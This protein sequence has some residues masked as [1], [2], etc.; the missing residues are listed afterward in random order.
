MRRD[1]QLFFGEPN[2]I[3]PC[4]MQNA[5]TLAGI[6]AFFI[7]VPVLLS[8]CAALVLARYSL[9]DEVHLL[10]KVQ[11]AR[12]FAGNDHAHHTAGSHHQTAPQMA[13]DNSFDP[14]QN[15]RIQD[16][17]KHG[18]A[19]VE[20]LLS[21]EERHLLISS[22]SIKGVQHRVVRSIALWALVTFVAIW[23][24]SISSSQALFLIAVCGATG[25]SS[26]VAWKLLKYKTIA[27]EY[28]QLKSFI[29]EAQWEGQKITHEAAQL[30]MRSQI[31]VMLW[32]DR[33]RLAIQHR[34]RLVHEERPHLVEKRGPVGQA[35]QVRSLRRQSV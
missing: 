16:D 35:G 20:N 34:I 8:S 23:A 2:R 30:S 5:A 14:V 33:A 15:E 6:R 17:P 22:D 21:A 4:T 26:T 27:R 10:V 7:W 24:A 19:G 32:L 31:S 11:L 29:N 3:A 28:A 18:G 1:N 25:T 13:G 12:R 9:S